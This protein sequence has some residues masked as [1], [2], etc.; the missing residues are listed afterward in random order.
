MTEKIDKQKFIDVVKS[1]FMILF[2]LGTLGAGVAL[3]VKGVFYII[4]SCAL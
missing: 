3:I 4:G 1:I 2:V